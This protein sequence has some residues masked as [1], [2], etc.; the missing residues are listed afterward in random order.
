V[1]LRVQSRRGKNPANQQKPKA[2]PHNV[3]NI[4]LVSSNPSETVDF[5]YFFFDT[6]NVE[7][8]FN[9][10]IRLFFRVRLLLVFALLPA[11]PRFSAFCNHLCPSDRE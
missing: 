8:F 4:M 10:D 7:Y 9:T 5:F 1:I 2:I 6:E 3:F 11:F